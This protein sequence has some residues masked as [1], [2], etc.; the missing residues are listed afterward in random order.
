MAFWSGRRGTV[1]IEFRDRA[2]LSA[3]RPRSSCSARILC[4]RRAHLMDEIP[5]ALK[6][7]Q[8]T[9]L[10]LAKMLLRLQHLKPNRLKECDKGFDLKSEVLAHRIMH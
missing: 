1:V 5:R 4:R 3:N 10:I 7:A 9:R 2:E 8:F 6:V